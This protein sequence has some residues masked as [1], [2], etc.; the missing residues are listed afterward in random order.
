ML[1]CYKDIYQSKPVYFN[2]GIL[3]IF[4]HLFA[5]TWG[6][7]LYFLIERMVICFQLL[8][9]MSVFEE[10]NL[11]PH[12]VCILLKYQRQGYNNEWSGLLWKCSLSL[13]LVVFATPY[14]QGQL[15]YQLQLCNIVL[16][17]ILLIN[18]IVLLGIH[19]MTFHLISKVQVYIQYS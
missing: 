6:M 16:Q 10:P 11:H 7:S 2:M 9:A 19:L 5:I 3:F 13:F 17:L 12:E 18:A 14:K 1:M 8:R 4:I 15:L